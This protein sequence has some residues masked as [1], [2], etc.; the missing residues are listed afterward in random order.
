MAV[1]SPANLFAGLPQVLHDE[2]FTALVETPYLR[3]ERIVSPP[4]HQTAPGDW[5]DQES[6]E[7][8]L[9]LEGRAALE[10]EN[11]AA[12]VE[13]GPGDHVV[14]APGVRHRVSWTAADRRTVWLA[15]HYR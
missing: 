4:G 9:L 8:V 3:I 2:L 13:L 12:P 11:G 10:L 7:W 6:H 14:L 1:P 5:Y 15:V